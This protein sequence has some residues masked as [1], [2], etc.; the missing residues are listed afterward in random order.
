M[1][2]P[3]LSS[4]LC[5]DTSAPEEA[6]AHTSDLLYCNLQQSMWQE[7]SFSGAVVKEEGLLRHWAS[8]TISKNS[9]HISAMMVYDQ[10]FHV[11][12]LLSRQ[13][14]CGNWTP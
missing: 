14:L 3:C 11:Y 7:Q 5:A 13:S 4:D 2:S 6:Y 12:M 1:T 10:A 9:T 8:C